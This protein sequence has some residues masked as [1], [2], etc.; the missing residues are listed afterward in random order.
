MIVVIV[1]VMQCEYAQD[2]ARLVVERREKKSSHG[3]P[4][5]TNT[6]SYRVWVRLRSKFGFYAFPTNAYPPTSSR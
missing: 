1:V 5:S 6:N 2:S 4:G 3:I